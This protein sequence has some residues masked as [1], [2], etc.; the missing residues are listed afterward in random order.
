MG[1][2]LRLVCRELSRVVRDLLVLSVDPSRIDDPEI[3]G[4]GEGARLT[5]LGARFSREDL[6]RAFDLLTRAENDIRGA[7]LPRYHLEMALLKWIY[8]RKLVPIEELIAG[9][10]AGPSRPAK[11]APAVAAGRSPKPLQEER[12]AAS[13]PAAIRSSL[14]APQAAAVPARP[15]VPAK[16]DFSAKADL[17]A[18]ADFKDALLAEI[19]KSKVGFYNIVVAQAQTI[20][21]TTDRVTF[22]FS[23][24]QRSIR[25]MFERDR[26]WL[27]SVAHQVS[28]RKIIVESA[29]GDGATASSVSPAPVASGS[30]APVASAAPAPDAGSEPVSPESN[31]EKAADRKSTLKKQAMA[32]AGV[33][34]LLEVFPAE[35]R[36]VE[37]M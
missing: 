13:A 33:Q 7:A 2:D 18:K 1:Y 6:L 11:P 10:G 27:E 16:A 19:R 23:P 32:D 14:P 20:D 25:D 36:D 31:D 22:T 28:G 21:V 8:V 35:I 17:P 4:E 34:A 26:A 5:A 30:R 37:E 9:G 29:Q 3:A 12:R 24:S 15:D